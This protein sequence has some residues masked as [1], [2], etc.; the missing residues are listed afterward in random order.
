MNYKFLNNNNEDYDSESSYDEKYQK[1]KHK[2]KKTARKLSQDLKHNQV[3]CLLGW[4][5][6]IVKEPQGNEYKLYKCKAI[7]QE[8]LEDLCEELDGL[9]V[10][11]PWHRLGIEDFVFFLYLV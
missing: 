4:E 2:A 9:L 10:N 5:K 1:R 6:E 11:F 3:E 7:K 8:K